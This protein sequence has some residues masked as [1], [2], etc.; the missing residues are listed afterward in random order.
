M[1]AHHGR[2]QWQKLTLAGR[3]GRHGHRPQGRAARRPRRL[4]RDRRRRRAGARRLHVQLDLQVPGLP[5]R[6]PDGAHQQDLDRR[7]PRRRPARG[8][9]RHRADDGRARGRGRRRPA[10]DPGEELDQARGVPVHHGRRA[11]LR[12]RQLRGRHGAG[13]GDVRVRRAAGRAEAAPRRPAT[14]SS[15]ASASRPS[16][17]CA[18]WRPSR[19]LGSL[20][21]GAGGWEHASVRMLATGKV[22]VVTG[23]SAHGQGHETAFSQIVADRLGVPFEDVEVLHGDTA[24]AHKGL[25]TYGSRSLV[26]GGEALVKAVDKVIEKATPIAAHLL[27]ASVDDIE[28]S[29]GRFSRPG[30]RPGP[31]HRRGRARDVRGAQPTRRASSR[32][33]TPRRRTTRSTSTSRTAPTCARWRSTPRPA[34]VTMRKYVCVRRHR[35]HHQPADRRRAGARRARPGHRPGALGGGGVRRL[36]HAGDAAPSSTTCCRRRPTRSPSTST[37]RPVAV[38]HE[39]ARHQGRR[40]GG[41]DRLDAGRGQRG[42]R[43][44]PALRRQRHPRCRARPSG[45]GRRSTPSSATGGAT[46]GAAM[47]HFDAAEPGQSSTEGAGA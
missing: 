24:I 35:Q 14:R 42:G 16:P 2:D 7:L 19:V 18:A 20:D 25:D 3:E 12:L 36:R 11:D 5:L 39:H 31:G 47:P 28:F 32:T 44:D 1:S 34:Q 8:D 17:R 41:H 13:Q 45:C 29:A 15:S 6:L 21:Y 27:E 26:V 46:E 9:V 4:R 33:S 43:R 30:H 10:R 22:E 37:T 23:A 38:D 40:R